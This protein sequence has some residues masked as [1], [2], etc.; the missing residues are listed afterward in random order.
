MPNSA[1]ICFLKNDD[2]KY[3][4]SNAWKDQEGRI[5][6]N[7]SYSGV[8]NHREAKEMCERH[9]AR[10]P[11]R[12]DFLRANWLRLGVVNRRLEDDYSWAADSDPKIPGTAYTYS[13]RDGGVI[14][15]NTWVTAE[16][17]VICIANEVNR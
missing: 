12:A 2:F 1:R 15:D 3:Q 14:Q 16:R 13:S 7:P 5:W 9:Y 10:L 11:T 4:L 17:D 6:G 8:F